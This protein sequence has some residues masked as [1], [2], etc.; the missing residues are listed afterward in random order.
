VLLS[1]LIPSLAQRREKLEL[2]LAELRAQ[3]GRDSSE[4]ETEL[5][6]LI[7]GG[8]ESIGRKRNTLLQ[9]ARGRFVAFI[10]DDDRVSGDYIKS[11]CSILQAHPGLDCVGIRG[12]VY[13]QGGH[14][15]PFVHSVHYDRYFKKNGVYHR[16]P[17]HLNPMRCEI[18]RRFGFAE[19]NALEDIDFAMRLSRAGALR[20]EILIDRLLYHYYCRRAWRTQQLIDLSEPFRHPLGLQRVNLMRLK[21]SITETLWKRSSS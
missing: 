21:R 13:F 10:D 6:T 7:D 11:I 3:I 17:Y 2:L 12:V 15:T 16:P 14:P 5:L 18:A 8:E 19:V 4:E 20:E 1:I 9:L